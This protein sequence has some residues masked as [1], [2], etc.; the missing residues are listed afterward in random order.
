MR[1]IYKGCFNV[2]WNQSLFQV[3]NDEQE[4]QNAVYRFMEF[5]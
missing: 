1:K 4:M 5:A 3:F 2:I